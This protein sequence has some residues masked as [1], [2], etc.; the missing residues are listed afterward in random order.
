[1]T[2]NVALFRKLV[3]RC[4]VVMFR[5]QNYLVE[6]RKRL[7]LGLKSDITLGYARDAERDLAPFVL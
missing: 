6:F 3:K 1:M 7:G 5:H 4:S 2:Q